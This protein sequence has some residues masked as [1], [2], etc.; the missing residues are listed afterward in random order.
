MD[1]AGLSMSL[2]TAKLGMGV[3]L[4]MLSKVLDTAEQTGEVLTGYPDA[5][6]HHI[7]AVSYGMYPVW[8][9]RGR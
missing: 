4:A 7:D 8:R 2:S 5:A 9:R 3:E 6:N 1:I